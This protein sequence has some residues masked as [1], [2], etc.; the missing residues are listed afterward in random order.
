MCVAPDLPE[1]W[2]A[3]LTFMIFGVIALT[4]TCLLLLA[5]PFNDYFVVV[6]RWITFFGSKLMNL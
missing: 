2:V 6:A 3:T 5:S 4:L 1:E